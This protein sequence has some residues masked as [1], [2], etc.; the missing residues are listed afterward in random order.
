MKITVVFTQSLFLDDLLV[1]DQLKV[2]DMETFTMSMDCGSEIY[3]VS[4]CLFGEMGLLVIIK[5]ELMCLRVRPKTPKTLEK[6]SPARPQENKTSP[7]KDRPLQI[8][9]SFPRQKSVCPNT[10]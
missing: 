7:S 8:F 4:I 3:N 10:N 5:I 6:T 1:D 2:H 9:V